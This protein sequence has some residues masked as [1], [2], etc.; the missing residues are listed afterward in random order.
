MKQSIIEILQRIENAGYQAYLVGG[1]CRDYLLHLPIADIDIATNAPADKIASLFE[2]VST[3]GVHFGCIKIK[4]QEIVAEITTFRQEKYDY[5]S[6]YPEVSHFVS[7]YQEDYIRRDFTINAIYIDA[8]L[9]IYDPA[10]GCKDLKKRRI[11]FIGDAKTRILE[12]PT[13]IFRLLRFQQRLH[14]H[15]PYALK[16]IIMQNK[17]EIQRLSKTRY[18]KEVAALE[19]MIGSRKTKKIL[20]KY[21]ICYNEKQGDR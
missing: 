7:T 2:V 18:Y 13:R 9:K 14:F 17:K 10:N 11:R 4:Y 8:N 19:Q 16:K 20:K 12:D 15:I 3:S 5:H 1:A 6:I 21:K